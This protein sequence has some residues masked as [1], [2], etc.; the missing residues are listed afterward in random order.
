LNGYESVKD[1]ED[2]IRREHP[3]KTNEEIESMVSSAESK[4]RQAENMIMTSLGSVVTYRYPTRTSA[5]DDD[6]F[7]E[8]F[9]G[10][11]SG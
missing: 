6:S 9:Y 4:M 3:H 10:D 5:Y 1:F 2:S 11:E 8:S 7:D